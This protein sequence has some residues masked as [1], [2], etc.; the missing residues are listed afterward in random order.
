MIAYTMTS[1]LHA[2]GRVV[3]LVVV[4]EAINSIAVQQSQYRVALVDTT[5]SLIVVDCLSHQ[6]VLG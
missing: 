3:V 5:E 4:V 6:L 2:A 1:P